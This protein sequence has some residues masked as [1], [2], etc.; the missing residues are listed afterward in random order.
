VYRPFEF[1]IPGTTDAADEMVRHLRHRQPL[2]QSERQWLDIEVT[3]WPAGRAFDL[4]EFAVPCEVADRH[5]LDP[6]RLK[7]A[8]AVGPVP[9]ALQLDK[10]GQ[11]SE[12]SGDCLTDSRQGSAQIARAGESGAAACSEDK[13]CRRLRSIREAGMIGSL[14]FERWRNTEP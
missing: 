2:R 14:L 11:T 10:L 5:W 6:E 4:K 8:T 12:Q 9:I 7:L 3:G 1:V 13:L